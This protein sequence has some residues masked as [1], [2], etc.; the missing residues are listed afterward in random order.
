MSKETF[1]LVIPGNNYSDPVELPVLPYGMMWAIEHRPKADF[2]DQKSDI[3]NLHVLDEDSVSICH[4]YQLSIDGG[5]SVTE[6][7]VL[8][9][10]DWL[11]K[12]LGLSEI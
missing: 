5:Y 6:E 7:D 1:S 9:C 2:P 3:W 8:E 12:R 10:A 11:L 4:Y